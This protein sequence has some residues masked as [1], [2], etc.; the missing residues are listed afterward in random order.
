MPAAQGKEQVR[1][2]LGSPY[3]DG[4]TIRVGGGRRSLGLTGG[5]QAG[6]R[7]ICMDP[8][9]CHVSLGRGLP[10]PLGETP[11]RALSRM[12]AVAPSP[13]DTAR[14][15][16]FLKAFCAIAGEIRSRVLRLGAMSLNSEKR[17]TSSS[18]GGSV[19]RRA[20]PNASVPKL[21]ERARRAPA[22]LKQLPLSPCFVGPDVRRGHDPATR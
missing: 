7:P 16:P 5:F 20:P 3:T 6:T 9:A 1:G 10:V 14:Q 4:L 21:Q 12:W 17:L 19:E 2:L 15:R 11:Q 22:S 18:S 8:T 13:P